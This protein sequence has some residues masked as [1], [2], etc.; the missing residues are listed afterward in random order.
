[1]EDQMVKA[2]GSGVFLSIG[3]I[4]AIISLFLY[5]FIFGV[6]GVIMGILATKR[7]SRAGITLIM[8]SIILMGI[9]LIYSGVLM[10]YTRHF[11]GL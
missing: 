11:L 10:N 4:A 7:H 5:P 8:A 1:M 9:G 2:R 3:W 6:L